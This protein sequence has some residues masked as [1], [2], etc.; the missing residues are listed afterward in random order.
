MH[1]VLGKEQHS[2]WCVLIQYK[3]A[4]SGTKLQYSAVFV[5]C[6]VLRAWHGTFLH[7]KGCTVHKVVKET[8]PFSVFQLFIWRELV[9]A[10]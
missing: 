2:K 3:L 9:F 4:Q 6:S 7:K 10:V 5:N 8:L 1:I